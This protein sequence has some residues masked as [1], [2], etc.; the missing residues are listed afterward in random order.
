MKEGKSRGGRVEGIVKI[1]KI[2]LKIPDPG[3]SYFQTD[4]EEGEG[5]EEMMEDRKVGERWGR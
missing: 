5:W 2:P 1:P 3:P 4:R